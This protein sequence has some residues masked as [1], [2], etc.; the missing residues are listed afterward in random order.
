MD[1][2]VWILNLLI[3]AIVLA[4]DVGRRRVTVMRLLRPVIAAAIIIPFFFKGA[5]SS[6]TGLLLEIA[7]LVT[8]AVLGALAGSLL[9]V[10]YDGQAGRAVSWAGWPYALVWVAVT[11]GRIY[12]TYGA[13]HIF[14][15]QLGGWL[16]ANQ[17]SVGALTDSLIFVSIAMLLGRT[18]I[19]AAKARVATGRVASARGAALAPADVLDPEVSAG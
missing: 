17:V 12:F 13:S 19:L 1:A 5:A 8:G 7:G 4:A 3:L 2:S 15:H 9:R 6:G 16:V 18:G 14:S 10:R 11:A